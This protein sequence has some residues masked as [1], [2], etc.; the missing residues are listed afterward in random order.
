MS[1]E[2]GEKE[3]HPGQPL[4]TSLSEANFEKFRSDFNK[5]SNEARRVLLLSPT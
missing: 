3:H 2:E 5:A 1:S 4:L